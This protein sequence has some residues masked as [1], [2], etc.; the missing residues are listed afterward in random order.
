MSTEKIEELNIKE[1]LDGSAV[2]ELPDDI[3]SPDPQDDDDHAEGGEVS[4]SD[5]TDDDHEPE[6]ETELQRVRR[7]KRRAKKNL[8]KQITSEKELKLQLLES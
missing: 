1:E 2:I 6:G 3:E 5:D 8:A 7:E 4:A